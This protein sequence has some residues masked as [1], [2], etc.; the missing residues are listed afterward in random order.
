MT[1][2]RL[3]SMYYDP[4]CA[5]GTHRQFKS[6]IG[7]DFILASAQRQSPE[8]HKESGKGR[9]EERVGPIYQ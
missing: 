3:N 8:G 5:Q 6:D 4:S 2:V 7:N 9:R 1:Q